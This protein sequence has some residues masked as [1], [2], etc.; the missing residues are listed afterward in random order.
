[1]SNSPR[2]T[3]T[4][5]GYAPHGAGGPCGLN[6]TH[7]YS[8][9]KNAR[10]D[11]V[12][13]LEKKGVVFVVRKML[14]ILGLLISLTASTGMCELT[15]DDEFYVSEEMLN[16]VS[17]LINTVDSPWIEDFASQ[18]PY[19]GTIPYRTATCVNLPGGVVD[20]NGGINGIQQTSDAFPFAWVSGFTIGDS[21]DSVRAHFV[22]KTAKKGDPVQWIHD[23]ANQIEIVYL[24]GIRENKVRSKDMIYSLHLIFH[25]N[26]LKI[27]QLDIIDFG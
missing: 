14:L 22:Q 5:G 24:T 16:D 17:R 2:W 11:S 7:K 9:D 23:D 6:L 27:M 3:V 13:L 1:V 19:D 25:N 10:K 20:F 8:S 15:C 4:S 21:V 18:F 26:Y 12:W